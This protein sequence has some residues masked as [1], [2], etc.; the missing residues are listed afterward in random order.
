MA[1]VNYTVCESPDFKLNNGDIISLR[2]FGKYIINGILGETKK[3]RL[4]FSV[5]KYS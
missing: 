1:L 2:K 5:K 3:G 4:K